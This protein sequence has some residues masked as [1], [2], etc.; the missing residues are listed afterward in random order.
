MFFF[1]LSLRTLF[2]ENSIN[3]LIN[4]DS[5]FATNPFKP[6]LIISDDPEPSCTREGIPEA[7]ASAIYKPNDSDKDVEINKSIEV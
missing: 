2:V 1:S 4:S 5:F 6:S 7:P 3:L